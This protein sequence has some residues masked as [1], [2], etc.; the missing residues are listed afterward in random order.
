MVGID[1]DVL[2]LSFQFHR[3]ARQP[4]N[5]RFLARVRGE[6][7]AVAIYTVIELLGQL[8]FNLSPDQL[9]RWPDWLQKEYALFLVY[10]EFAAESVEQFF[11]QELVDRPFQRMAQR[12]PYQDALILGLIERVPAIDAFVTWNARHFQRKTNLPVL[13]PAEYLAA[14]RP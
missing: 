7:P 14:S 9:A 10:P 1:T 12:M 6:N 2:L 13:T 3:D 8:S 11:Q 5:T 4:I